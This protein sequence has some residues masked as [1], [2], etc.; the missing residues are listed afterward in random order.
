MSPLHKSAEGLQQ[1]CKD[2]ARG[3]I[4]AT[5]GKIIPAPSETPHANPEQAS[6]PPAWAKAMKDHKAF[7]HSPQIAAHTPKSGDGRGA[8]HHNDSQPT[9]KAML[10]RPP[11]S[12][13]H[14]PATHP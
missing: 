9:A 13:D 5:G 4:P 2:G 11:T 1:S 6:G 8:G 3:A 12:S 14:P 10:C 7:L